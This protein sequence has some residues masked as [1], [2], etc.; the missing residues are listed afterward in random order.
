[1]VLD[2]GSITKMGLLV[3]RVRPRFLGGTKHGEGVWCKT[4]NEAEQDRETTKLS[5]MMK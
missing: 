4:R 2:L 5:A 3:D 1:M